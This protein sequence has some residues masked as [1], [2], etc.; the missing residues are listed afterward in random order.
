[1]EA[2]QQRRLFVM[3]GVILG[4]LCLALAGL[5]G[6]LAYVHTFESP[7][8]TKFVR[9]QQEGYTSIPG[10]RGCIVDRHGRILA[11][12]RDKPSV[13]ADPSLIDNV[14]EV[15][16]RLAPVIGLEASAVAATIEKHRGRRFCRIKRYVELA[17]A[18]AVRALG[19]RGLMVRDES[20][21]TYPTELPVGPILGFVGTDGQGL[22]GIE[23]QF[24][25]HL[26]AVDGRTVAVYD[27]RRRR[28]PI[29]LR[30][31]LS[32]PP[33]DGGHVVLTIDSVIQAIAYEEVRD[34]AETFDARYAVGMV[35]DPH[36]GE[37]LAMTQHPSYA[38]ESFAST[39][40]EHRRNYVVTNAMEPGSTFKPFVASEAISM[41]VVDPTELID[42]KNGLHY[43]G[44][45]RMRDT[46]PK[47][48]LDFVGILTYS[49]NIGMGFIAERMGNAAVH[50]AVRR[51]GFGQPTG[52][53]FVGEAS[54]HVRPLSSWTSYSTHSVPIGQELAVTPL[55]LINGF[56]AIANGGTLL[57][58][59]LVRA[60]MTAE[61][62]EVARTDGRDVVRQVLS[63]EAAR[64]MREVALVNVVKEGGGRRAALDDWQVFGKTGTAQVAFDDRAGYEPEAYMGAFLAGA[65]AHDPALVVLVMVYRPDAE[66]G[67]YGSKVAAPAVG[68]I[69]KRSLS[70]LRVPADP[71]PESEQEELPAA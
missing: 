4:A 22:E 49:S 51:F 10:R 25:E 54:G 1:M 21:R 2:G 29:W 37:V 50:D 31:D 5:V 55:Q 69:L 6:R 27:G 42:C 53:D 58:P 66:L 12:T 3:G 36:S 35:M 65:P 43:F 56:A 38:S 40:A 48:E 33:Q 62:D 52:I 68:E 8:L 70:Y 11:G 61:G 44:G 14:A 24:N 9:A 32:R 60:M 7:K 18:D 63:K 57:R 45:Q 26:S 30:D 47:G 23:L 13:M 64:Y 67:Y 46:K 34:A 71:K 59:R 17:E 19:I 15:A 41:G 20:Q 28:R 39:P 16:E